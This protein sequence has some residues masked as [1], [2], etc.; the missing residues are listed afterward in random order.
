MKGQ[1]F[2]DA[3]RVQGRVIW[4]L[5]LR[6]ILGK[7][8]RDK[9]GYFWQIIRVAFGIAVFWGIREFLGASSQQN[10]P[11]VVFLV[12][13]FV[14]WSIF[15]EVAVGGISAVSK[16]QSLLTFSHVQP[17]D[18]HISNLTVSW[19]TQTIVMFIILWVA[20]AMGYKFTL[21]DSVAFGGGLVGVGLF[22]FGTG[23]CLA[24][25]CK[26]IPVAEYIIGMVM[27]LL[28]FTSGIFFSP[29]TFGQGFAELLYWNPI[30]NYIELI[31]GAFLYRSPDPALKLEFTFAV[32]AMVL[33][34]GML[35]ERH[36]RSIPDKV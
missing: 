30:T 11:Q 29:A 25:L 16:G 17:L 6:D 14:P 1:T 3:L 18:L 10:L 28:F 7:N 13:G 33:C 20:L 24:A 2:R 12:C 23:L 21:L 27:R 19:T 32:T 5:S 31:R 26:Y 15:N 36:I 22:A 35:M 8:T 4:A 9:L 34:V